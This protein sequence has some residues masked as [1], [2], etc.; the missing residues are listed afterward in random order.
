MWNQ[1]KTLIAK[2]AAM[3]TCHRALYSGLSLCHANGC[4][5]TDY[6]ALYA[7]M[8]VLYAALALRG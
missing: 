7:P 6:P 1:L 2:A 3:L 5:L 8:A 4:L